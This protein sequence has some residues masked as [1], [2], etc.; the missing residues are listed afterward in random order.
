M[1]LIQRVSF[2]RAEDLDADNIHKECEGHLYGYVVCHTLPVTEI[3]LDKNF[4]ER[5]RR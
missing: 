4:L 3:F 2:G 5:E 1:V